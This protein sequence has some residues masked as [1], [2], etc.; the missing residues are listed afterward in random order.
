MANIAHQNS[1][2]NKS[3]VLPDRARVQVASSLH[4][5]ERTFPY[6]AAYTFFL[7]YGSLSSNC[8]LNICSQQLNKFLAFN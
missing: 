1:L 8:C 7:V 5:I 2:S 3:S 4:N 6:L